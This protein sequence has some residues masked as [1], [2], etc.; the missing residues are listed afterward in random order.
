MK[1]ASD[2]GGELTCSFCGKTP[3]EVS[4]LVAGP[5]VAIC[6]ACVTVCNELAE[7][8]PG[9]VAQRASTGRGV[10]PPALR[11][12]GDTA[13]EPTSARRPP[14][15]E[16]GDRIAVVAPAGAFDPA[17]LA[18]G[19][20]RLR[21]RGFEVV[22]RADIAERVRYLAG[23]D[24]RRAAELEEA[25][26]DPAVKAVL[27]ARGGYGAARA[28]EQALALASG[29]IARPKI[30]VGYSDITFLLS[31]I[32][33]GT[34]MITFHGPQV[35]VDLAAEG[36]EASLDDLLATLG[37][38]RF[39][40]AFQ[41][42]P[43]TPLVAGR[44]EGTLLG[45]CLSMLVTMIGTPWE[46]SFRDSILFLEDIAEPAFRID[47]MLTHLRQAG[48]LDG[49]RGVVIGYLKDVRAPEGTTIEEVF[50]D[51]LEPLGIPVAMGLEAGH[52]APC[53][54]LPLGVSARLDASAGTL[55][56]LE[57]VVE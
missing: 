5:G 47:R 52:G 46:P 29:G 7:E 33:A 53:R 6:D 4:S 34:G 3:D 21:T 13:S 2:T 56:V 10:T 48:C 32:T 49:V 50:L 17:A 15:L 23:S 8:N 35:A 55:E 19:V 1:R 11:F 37:G 31:A 51:C 54:T 39:P 38:R 42:T 18:R 14:R 36:A 16:P 30:L 12:R 41:S 25:L 22:H 9:G 27:C 24:R 57:P 20:E 45:G 44:A 26:V 28:L 43:L 40:G